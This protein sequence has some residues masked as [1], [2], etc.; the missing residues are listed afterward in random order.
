MGMGMGMEETVEVV[1]V[2][3]DGRGCRIWVNRVDGSRC[4]IPAQDGFEFVVV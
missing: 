2:K 3:E 1:E 4:V